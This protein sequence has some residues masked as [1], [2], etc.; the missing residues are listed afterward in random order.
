MNL[1]ETRLHFQ[2]LWERLGYLDSVLSL[3]GIETGYGA[4]DAWKNAIALLVAPTISNEVNF[5]ASLVSIESPEFGFGWTV[6][7]LIGD[8]LGKYITQ[9]IA[10][11]TND[12]SLMRTVDPSFPLGARPD[13]KWGFY[14][15][16]TPGSNAIFN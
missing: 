9:I 15:P 11:S 7:T 14:V 5:A 12:S 10:V 8:P 1:D 6:G 2:E 3:A 4:F 16:S 13:G